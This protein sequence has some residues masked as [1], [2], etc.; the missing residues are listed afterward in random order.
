MLMMMMLV[1]NYE[2]FLLYSSFHSEDIRALSHDVI[3][4]PSEHRQ[5]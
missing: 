1:K 3:V 4:K 5:F 2:K